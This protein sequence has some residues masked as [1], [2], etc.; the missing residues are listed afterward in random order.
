MVG[1]HLDEAFMKAEGKIILST[2]A[3]NVN[4]VQQVVN[5]AMKTNRKLALL[6]EVW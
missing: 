2:F 6:D 5:A 1:E 4:R 3:S